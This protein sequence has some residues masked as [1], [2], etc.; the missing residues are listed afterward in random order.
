MPFSHQ[1]K[2]SSL[3]LSILPDDLP[4]GHRLVIGLKSPHGKEIRL[5]N[6]FIEHISTFSARIIV[7]VVPLESIIPR[8]YDV[9][10]EDRQICNV[11]DTFYDPSS[12]RSLLQAEAGDHVFRVLVRSDLKHS[13]FGM[14]GNAREKY[15]KEVPIPGI[16]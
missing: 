4:D 12:N 8:G 15:W 1:N 14:N 7:L 10:L 11:R 16:R 6:V 3:C 13:I 9:I 2:K 5:S